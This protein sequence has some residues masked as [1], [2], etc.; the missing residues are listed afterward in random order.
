LARKG[1]QIY[2]GSALMIT[3]IPTFEEFQLGFS[4]DPAKRGWVGIENEFRL[5]RGGISVPEAEVALRLV[6][7]SILYAKDRQLVDKEFSACEFE[8]KN[9]PHPTLQASIHAM[10]E[11]THWCRTLLA[12]SGLELVCS[13]L[14]DADVPLDVYPDP[15]YEVIAQVCERR[16]RAMCRVAALQFTVGVGDEDEMI[17]VHNRLISALPSILDDP[18]CIHPDRRRLFEEDIYP[19][20]SDFRPYRDMRDLYEHMVLLR[21]IDQLSN[22]WPWVRCRPFGAVEFRAF[23]AIDDPD[24]MFALGQRVLNIASV[25]V[26]HSQAA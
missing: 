4:F 6:R 21:V 18:S 9:H 26:A 25:P 2:Q 1:S 3:S 11:M 22:H 20:I 23:G 13:E 7:G 16:R 8:I 10:A 24:C 17:A 14:V 12:Q 5:T 15:R 19:A